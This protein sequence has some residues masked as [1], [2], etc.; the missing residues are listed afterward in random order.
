MAF[1]SVKKYGGPILYLIVYSL[2]L[3]L[4][5]FWIDGGSR[6]VWCRSLKTGLAGKVSPSSP[7]KM[8]GI[9]VDATEDLLR[10][11]NISKKFSG[12]QAMEDVNLDISRN[13]IFALLGPNGAGK[14]TTFNIIREHYIQAILPRLILLLGGSILPDNGD[15]F[16]NGHSIVTEPRTARSYLGVCPQFTA[17]DI[18]LTVREHMMVYARLKGLRG[19]EMK[20]SIDAILEGTSLSVYADRMASKLSGGNQRKL[21]LAIALL[22][23][24]LVILIDEFSTGVDPKMK[25]EMWDVLR[26]VAVGKAIVITTRKSIHF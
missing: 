22:G 2:I 9:S 15:V 7:E 11:L 23:N 20:Q 14:T 24:P 19:S 13:T 25:R 4:I 10:V 6:R 21:S 16:I 3:L 8:C 1:G 17:I 12:K 18:Q 26:K 5:L